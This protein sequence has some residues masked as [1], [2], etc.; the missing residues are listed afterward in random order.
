VA[1]F[2]VNLFAHHS[3]HGLSPQ[4]LYTSHKKH[5]LGKHSY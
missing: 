1:L 2:N 3:R 5:E 4:N